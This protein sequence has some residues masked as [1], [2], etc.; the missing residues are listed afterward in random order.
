MIFLFNSNGFESAW[1][2]GAAICNVAVPFTNVLKRWT[3]FLQRCTTLDKVHQC[4]TTWNAQ[5]CYNVAQ[6]CIT[7]LQR[8]TALY[9]VWQRCY[10]VALRCITFGNVAQRWT[11]AALYNLK[12]CTALIQ[13]R[14]ALLQRCTTL[15]NVWQ[16]CG[17]IAQRWI[18]FGNVVQLPPQRCTTLQFTAFRVPFTTLQRELSTL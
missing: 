1:F 13:Q 15:D 14:T 9:N 17:N 8:C 4:C 5:L 18:T 11:M 3:A 2:V 7:L 10:N 6:R 16:R 12:R